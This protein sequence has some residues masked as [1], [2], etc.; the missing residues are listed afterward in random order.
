MMRLRRLGRRALFLA[1][2]E[3]GPSEPPTANVGVAGVW[4]GKNG[5]MGEAHPFA[6]CAAALVRLWKDDAP[7]DSCNPFGLLRFSC[8]TGGR[9]C[10]EEGVDDEAE[11][12]GSEWES[13]W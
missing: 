4:V 9:R 7:S 1:P 11:L 8:S 13:V 10:G 3:R 6:V 12:L 5:L 2:P